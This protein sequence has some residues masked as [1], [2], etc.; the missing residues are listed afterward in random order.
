MADEIRVTNFEA[1]RETVYSEP[2]HYAAVEC[3]GHHFSFSRY[4]E[5]NRWLCDS[6]IGPKGMPHFVHGHGSRCT[7]KQSATG[8]LHELIEAEAA[9]HG[10]QIGEAPAAES[11]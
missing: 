3:N 6:H 10:A 7:A 4:P 5:E 1:N 8:E 11:R 9:K 2:A